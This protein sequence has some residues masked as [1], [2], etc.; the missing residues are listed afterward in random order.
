MENGHQTSSSCTDPCRLL[1]GFIV[2]AMLFCVSPVAA[3]GELPRLRVSK[4][5]RYLVTEGEK[6]FFWLGDTAWSIIDQSM[7]DAS[8]DQ[9]G[10]ERYFQLRTQQGF[11]IVQ[12]HFLTNLVRGPI[13][14]PN[15]YGDRPFNNG[16]FTSPRVLP[17]PVND[18]WDHADYVIDLAAQYNMYIA[19]VAAWSNS[20]ETDDHPMVRD[21]QVAY[22]YGHFL[23][24]RYR[25]LTHIIWLLGG[26][27]FGRPDRNTLSPARG[28]MTRALAEGIADGVNGEHAFDGH[29]D[30]TTTLMSYHP[31]GGAKSS[32]RFLHKEPWLD[33]NMI[34]T[35]T[36]FRFKNYQTVRADYNRHP[37]KPTLDAEVAYEYSLPLNSRERRQRPGDRITPWDVRRAAYWNVFAGSLGHTYGHRNLIGWVCAREAA[38]KHGADRPWFESLDAP[39]ARQMIHLK[40]LIESRPML[41]RIPDQGLVVSGQGEGDHHIQAT[42]ASNGSFAFIYIPTGSPVTIDLEPLSGKWIVAQWVNPRTGHASPIGRFARVGHRLFTPSSQGKEQDWILVL[43]DAACEFALPNTSSTVYTH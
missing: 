24:Q 27:G 20:L 34:Q 39:G 2:L 42:R 11:N 31:P 3:H 29:V 16:D 22:G 32:S 14:A 8:D 9:P 6:P 21:P 37:A 38:L 5:A 41:M 35:T 15:T 12:T 33:F 40:T 7:R 17:G 19:V 18:Y 30:W 43:D 25:N 26:D 10:V 36:M 13:D 23:G 28:L 4:N 1:S